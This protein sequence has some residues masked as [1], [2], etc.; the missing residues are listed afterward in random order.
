MS[1]MR[2][3]PPFGGIKYT[4]TLA[5]TDQL[6][7]AAKALSEC[8]HHHITLSYDWQ[9]RPQLWCSELAVECLKNNPNVTIG[10]NR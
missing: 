5:S 8:H 2:F 4:I 1:D 9:D 7:A 10:E 6:I 3:P